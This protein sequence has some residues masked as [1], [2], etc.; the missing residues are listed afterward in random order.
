M[1]SLL[2]I[3]SDTHIGSS[4]A[5]ATPEFIVYNRHSLEEQVVHANSLQRWLWECWLDFWS[6]VYELQGKGKNAKRLIVVHCG[7]V[8]D[9]IYNGNAQ[10]MSEVADQVKLATDILQPIVNRANAFFGVY[11]TGIHAGAGNVS[12]AEIYER[13]GAQ[14]YGHQLT[15]EVDGYIHSFHH[16]GRAGARPWTSSAAGLASEVMIDYAQRGQKPPN[17]IWTGHKHIV[18]DSGMKFQETRAISLPSWQLK[19]SYGWK[20]AGNTVR[21]DIGGLI[22]LDGYIVDSSHARYMG[23]ADEG[24]KITV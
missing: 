23:Q 18:D 20:V 10:Q 15:L 3:I 7:D 1:G 14:D 2:V 22:V 24:S 6:Y 19:S 21:S 13:L 9:G 4:T 16:H 12:E 5:L 11:G 8:I 17:F